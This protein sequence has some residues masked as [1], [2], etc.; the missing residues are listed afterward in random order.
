[1]NIYR[2]IPDR[3]EELVQKVARRRVPGAC[4][5]R[6]GMPAGEPV[7]GSEDELVRARGADAV[8]GGLV[9]FQQQVR[10]LASVTS[11][12]RSVSYR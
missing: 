9:V 1:M 6:P 4:D 10:G 12:Q 7:S 5:L 2:S 3:V 8:N 11:R